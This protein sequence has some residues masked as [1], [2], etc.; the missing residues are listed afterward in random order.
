MFTCSSLAN[1]GSFAHPRGPKSI[2][3]WH[4][5]EQLLQKGFKWLFNR[6]A[7]R[8]VRKILRDRSVKLLVRYSIK[9]VFAKFSRLIYTI[10]K[11]YI[12]HAYASELRLKVFIRTNVFKYA[13]THPR[14]GFFSQLSNIPYY[15][16]FF[17]DCRV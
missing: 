7:W 17:S 6:Y 15:K 5:I 9:C 2:M 13:C 8:Q 12:L 10:Y 1:E 14:R 3:I 11:N 16:R 4:F